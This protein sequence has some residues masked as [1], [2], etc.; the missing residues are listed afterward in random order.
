MF[1]GACVGV[2][3]G[4]CVVSVLI[5]GF[6]TISFTQFVYHLLASL[7]ATACSLVRLHTTSVPVSPAVA[8]TN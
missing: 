8:V 2:T 5:S 7:S 1:I 3:I 4:A 6:L